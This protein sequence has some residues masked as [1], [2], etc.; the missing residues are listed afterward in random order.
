MQKN[1]CTCN[2]LS[3]YSVNKHTKF[4]RS[5]DLDEYEELKEQTESHEI[6]D[7]LRGNLGNS[8]IIYV[9][10]SYICMHNLFVS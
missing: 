4:K 8:Y 2:I 7:V 3:F 6:L 1:V 5:L 10:P 9:R